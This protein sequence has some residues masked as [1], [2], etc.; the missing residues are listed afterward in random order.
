MWKLEEGILVPSLAHRNRDQAT[1]FLAGHA[2]IGD[3]GAGDLLEL[4]FPEPGPRWRKRT[5]IRLLFALTLQGHELSF[6]LHLLD[7]TSRTYLRGLNGTAEL[8]P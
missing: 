7:A 2:W 4:F 3:T 5:K 6:D 1:L 8:K